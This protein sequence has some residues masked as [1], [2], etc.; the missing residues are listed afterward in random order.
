MSNI[1]TLRLE[2]TIH[3]ILNNAISS[4]IEN[5]LVRES[6]ITSVKLSPDKSIAKIYI[7]CFIQ[8]NI[9]KTLQAYKDV[10]GV[11]KFILSKKLTIRKVPQLVFYQDESI[12]NGMKIDRI[13]AEIKEEEQK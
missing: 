11:F 13:L 8:K 6:S 10:A 9:A 12:T 1:K 5:R 2:S 7:D 4:E 3:R